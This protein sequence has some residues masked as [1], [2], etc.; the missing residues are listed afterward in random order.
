MAVS[1]I[2]EGNPSTRRKPP[3]CHKSLANFITYIMVYRV[4]LTMNRVQTHSISGDRHCWN[5]Q[6]KIQ[7]PYDFDILIFGV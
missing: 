3:T 2:G 7:L 6:V 5:R 4:Y 1:F